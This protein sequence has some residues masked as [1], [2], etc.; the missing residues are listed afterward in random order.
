MEASGLL[1]HFRVYSL[2]IATHDLAELSDFPDSRIFY[3]SV[4]QTEFPKLSAKS[5]LYTATCNRIEL[6]AEFHPAESITN[7][8]ETLCQTSPTFANLLSKK[9]QV[10]QGSLMLEHMISVASGLKSLALGETQITGQLKRDVGFASK[11]GWI[12][13][14]MQTLVQKALETQKKIRTM[15]GISENSYS[16]M[17]LTEDAIDARGL[18]AIEGLVVLIGASQMSAKIAR[19]ALKRNTEKFLLVRKNLDRPMNA[20]LQALID[21]NPDKFLH[22]TLD[23]FQKNTQQW[24]VGALFLASSSPQPLF[25]AEHFDQHFAS[26]AIDSRTPIVDLSLP[27]N[28]SQRGAERVGRQLITLASL[29]ELSENARADRLSSAVQAAPIIRRA[30]YQFWLDT[31]HRE[32]PDLVQAYLETKTQQTETEWKRLAEEA[33]LNEKQK[34]ILYDFLKKEQRRALS[35]HKEMILDLLASSSKRQTG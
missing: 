14:G 16:L 12:S 24:K 34:R 30:I 17:S 1:D 13:Q 23:E 11:L 4:S 15:T 3:S 25:D 5:L 31:L 35:S 7:L 26:G 18:R 29:Q 27:P 22:T 6:Y 28:V 32:N 2:S 8:E 20:D 33:H 21:A 19:F 9:P 10:Y